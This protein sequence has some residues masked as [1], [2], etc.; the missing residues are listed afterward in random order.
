MDRKVQTFIDK[1]LVS[2]RENGNP[3]HV[4]ISGSRLSN[5][6]LLLRYQ[7]D[8]SYNKW[9]EFNDNYFADNV[10]RNFLYTHDDLGLYFTELYQGYKDANELYKGLLSS[11]LGE[12]YQD[13]MNLFEKINKHSEY[14]RSGAPGTSILNSIWQGGPNSSSN[15]NHSDLF[16]SGRNEKYISRLR[17]YNRK[18]A[19]LLADL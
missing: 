2:R 4:N 16:G 11:E 7:D 18:I 5:M 6:L 1:F 12:I 17:H 19:R 3:L 14:N 13:W 8:N 15:N 9:K 10:T